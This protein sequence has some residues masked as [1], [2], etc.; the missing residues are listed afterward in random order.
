MYCCF[1]KKPRYCKKM[2]LQELKNVCWRGRR[3]FYLIENKTIF[4]RTLLAI[5][6]WFIYVE[7]SITFKHTLKVDRKR[8]FDVSI[9]TITINQDIR[10][11]THL[12]P[13]TTVAQ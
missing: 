8:F 3:C 2:Y 11:F 7:F 9:C 5:V 6:C 13:A 1:L 10:T 12:T 4:F